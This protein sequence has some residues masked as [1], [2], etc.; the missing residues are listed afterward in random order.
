[1]APHTTEP[2]FA[3]SYAFV[4]PTDFLKVVFPAENDLDYSI[5][6]H[7]G[8]LAL[9]TNQTTALELVYIARIT[10]TTRFHPTFVEALAA[11]LALQC[12]ED[13]AGSSA[14]WERLAQDYRAAIVS[15]RR[16]NGFLQLPKAPPEAPWLQVRR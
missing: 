14:K 8:S 2:D 1:L 13:G 16:L 10:D 6:N 5:E 4:L 11:R 3:Y 12:C 15:A 7:E 9:L